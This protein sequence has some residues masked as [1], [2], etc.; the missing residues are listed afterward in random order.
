MATNEQ[1]AAEVDDEQWNGL[2]DHDTTDSEPIPIRPAP[3]QV[4][5]AKQHAEPVREKAAS[6]GQQPSWSLATIAG[7]A[8]WAEDA[9]GALGPRRFQ[10]VLELATF[11]ELLS[12]DATIGWS[13]SSS[14]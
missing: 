11:A 1:H 10:F 14:C 3:E 7:L 13:G 4:R 5:P 2:E 6:A 12:S 8:V 9:L